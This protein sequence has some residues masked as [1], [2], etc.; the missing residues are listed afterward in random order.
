[1]GFFFTQPT[2]NH[3]SVD[4]LARMARAARLKAS[5]LLLTALGLCA[6][7]NCPGI[8]APPITPGDVQENTGVVTLVVRNESGL[9]VKVTAEFQLS[10]TDVRT[11]V[12]ILDSE[13]LE[14]EVTLLPTRARLLHVLAVVGEDPAGSGTPTTQPGDHAALMQAGDVL[15]ESNFEWSVD[16]MDGDTLVIV[17]PAQSGPEAPGPNIIDCN[18]NGIADGVEIA[19]DPSKDCN[20][21]DIPDD[22][23][24]SNGTS[25]DCNS[26][27]IPDEC[28]VLPEGFRAA[29]AIQSQP[30]LL[31]PLDGSYTQAMNPN[32]DGSSALITLPFAFDLY[33]SNSTSLYINNNGN[34]S[35][36]NPF[37]TFTA[38]G[39]PVNGF[40]MVAPFWADVDT[41][42]NLGVVWYKLTANTLI[43]TWDNVGYFNQEGDKRNTFQVALSDGSNPIIGLGN[44]VAFSYADM[45]WTTGSASEGEN[46]FGGVAAT[47]GANR[48]NGVDSFQIGRFDQPGTAYDGPF[49]NNDGVDFLD[50]QVFRFSTATGQSNIAPIATG[51]PP[52]GTVRVNP[53]VG[54][55]LDLVVNLLSPEPLQTTTVQV[56]DPGGAI[57]AGLQ[58][59]NTPGNTATLHFSWSPT[60]QD[61]G[62]YD[63]ELTASDD[64]NPPGVSTASFRILVDCRSEDCNANGIPDECE[65]DCNENG[66]PD[67]CDIADCDGDPA[68]GDCNE[69]NI[70]DGCDIATEHSA[71]ANTD[72]IPDECDED[73]GPRMDGPVPYFKRSDGPVPIV[74]IGRPIVLQDFENSSLL[75]SGVTISAGALHGPSGV[76][77]SVDEDDGVVDGDGTGGHSLMAEDGAAGITFDF[78]A[79]E[80]GGLPVWVGV[81][82]TD[83][84]GETT[85]EAFGAD[86]SS[87][88]SIGPVPLA[89]PE[90]PAGST[91][92]DSFFGA[93][94][95]GGISRIRIRN[96]SGH[97][98]V[99]HLQ[100]AAP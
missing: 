95:P 99:D 74:V 79:Q 66:R 64:F 35:F 8:F 72:G 91:A 5:F 34:V 49:G 78:D 4:G 61:S 36:G 2:S 55:S 68:C 53:T 84:E 90:L 13:G 62:V 59:V 71:D 75:P 42:P 41:R 38:S 18:S 10:D 94:D 100:F 40:P 37:S 47:V 26:N 85:F 24:L 69:N 22:C 48:G 86:G 28:D 50:G 73:T 16:F 21:N 54:D 60:C 76:T 7:L 51:L 14:T 32:D 3:R 43:V 44:N 87:I 80:L 23:D 30:E 39:F 17:I 31:F 82:W 83:G 70:P 81:V 98:E 88:G 52:S 25:Q 9:K 96:S 56:S 46:G 92:N 27:G 6:G 65:T 1:M 12:R 63:I 45:Q 19:Q 93:T 11:T 57:A 97:I 67:D 33:G 89:D 15:V 29:Q 77:N 58:I 20:G